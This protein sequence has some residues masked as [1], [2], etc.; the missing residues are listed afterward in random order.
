MKEDR[1]KL[2]VYVGDLNCQIIT[3]RRE[4]DCF[5]EKWQDPAEKRVI[6]V[7]GVVDHCDSNKAEFYMDREEIKVVEIIEIKGL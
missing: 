6:T 7:E 3:S 5:R 1:V 4:A 2:R